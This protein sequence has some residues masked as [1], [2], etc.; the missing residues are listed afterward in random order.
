MSFTVTDVPVGGS[1][2]IFVS[3]SDQ[4]A[5]YWKLGSTGWAQYPTVRP[6]S[7]GLV[8]TLTDGGYGDAD[9]IAN[10]IIV[11]PGAIGVPNQGPVVPD[12]SVTT[13]P[14]APV[15]VDVL[16]SATD[17]D[18]G[19]LEVAGAT[20]GALGS[21]DVTPG[22][23]TYTPYAGATGQ[24]TFTVTVSDG[25]G[26][27]ATAT[28]TV[29]IAAP[30]PPPPTTTTPATAPPTTTLGTAPP[31]TEAA[32]PTVSTGGR[33]PNTGTDPSG[34]AG[35]ALLLLAAGLVL[36]ALARRRPPSKEEPG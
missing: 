5:G 18:G 33:L 27:T 20:N 15:D 31:T 35:A 25:Q 6:E 10:G 7:G 4:L 16:A 36:V 32:P 9:G 30:E 24:D 34:W 13:S 8:F 26:G 29:S 17:P 21:V 2:D 12:V 23:V 28:V 19:S 22:T 1:T 14:G 3:L 11:D